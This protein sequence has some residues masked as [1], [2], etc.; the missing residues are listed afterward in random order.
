MIDL[1]THSNASDGSL[2]PGA[3]VTEAAKRGLSALALTDHDTIDGLAEAEEAA[4]KA[5]IRFIRGI[6]LEIAWRQEPK[7]TPPGPLSGPCGEFHLLGLGINRPSP[8]FLAAVTE[9]IRCRDMRNQEILNRMAELN[10]EARYDDI[11]ALAG[12]RSIGR[13][14]FAAF[15]VNRGIVKNQEQAFSRYLSPGKPFYAPKAGLKFDRAVALIRESGG[16]AVIAHPMSLYVAWGKLPDLVKNLKEQGLDGLEAWHPTAKVKDCKRL[17][18]LGKTLGLRITAGS[19]F[20]G[21][22]RPDRKL[23]ITAGDKKIDDSF[24]EALNLTRN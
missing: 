9:L 20:H 19:D 13:L 24:L 1:H 16:I 6:E 23:G 21:E 5:G 10:I 18:E 7:E 17:E 11:K 14:H 15:L 4:G 22:A 3:L 8:A 2:S 12:G